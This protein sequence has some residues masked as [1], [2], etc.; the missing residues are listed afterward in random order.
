[1][2]ERRGLKFDVRAER[3][4]GKA[5]I[6]GY[7]AVFNQMSEDLGGFREIIEPGAFAEALKTDDVVG[8]Y[9]HDRNL[10][11]GR[12]SAGT[13]DLEED[14]KGLRYKI[15]VPDTMAGR[16]L[17]ESVERG[18]V[19]GSSFGFR[20]GTADWVTREV[21]DD[22]IDVHLVKTV[23]RLFDVGPV[24]FPAYP[25]TEAEVSAR[26]HRD[27]RSA[28]DAAEAAKGKDALGFARARIDLVVRGL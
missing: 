28:I 21:G 6:K 7:A 20:V 22:V 16:D 15:E 17:V 3:K 10:V 4:D 1:M 24:T 23:K 12:M 13:L 14:E 11:L 26:S 25:Q 27:W 8:L 9:N 18:D 2:N 5:F 19:V